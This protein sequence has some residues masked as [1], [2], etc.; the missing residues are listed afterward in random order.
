ME[1]YDYI[2]LNLSALSV[3]IIKEY[4]LLG[5]PTPDRPVY[6]K[7]RKGIYGLTQAI[8]LTNE[9]LEKRLNKH[10]YYQSTNCPRPMDTQ[11][12]TNLIHACGRQLWSQV[13]WRRAC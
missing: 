8:K 11:N 10:G 3:E 13:R 5:I 12:L 6:V 7:V 2:K 4:K 1:R 9:L